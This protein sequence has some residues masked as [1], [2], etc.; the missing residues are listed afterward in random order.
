MTL[1]LIKQL[2]WKEVA[3]NHGYLYGSTIHF[4]DQEAHFYNNLLASGKTIVRFESRTNYQGNRRS[5]DLPLLRPG[6]TY[7]IDSDIQTV[8]EDRYFLHLN[9]FNRQ[10]EV[11]GVEILRD[12]KQSFVCPQDTFTYELLVK[13]GGCRQMEFRQISIYQEKDEDI[14]VAPIGAYMEEAVPEEISLVKNL[15][16]T[17]NKEN[18]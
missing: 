3:N 11:V 9:F 12:S 5:P 16:N 8:P 10:N 7:T 4:S 1:V 15:I 13:S 14:L 2:K 17:Q 18:R 6:Q